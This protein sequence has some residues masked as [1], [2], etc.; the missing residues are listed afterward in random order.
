MRL[1]AQPLSFRV[2]TSNNTPSVRRKV[3]NGTSL[4]ISNEGKCA[5]HLANLVLRSAWVN[6]HN[7][8][9]N[10]NLEEL[11]NQ[12]E[13]TRGLVFNTRIKACFHPPEWSSR[14][15]KVLK[16]YEKL[17]ISILI[18]KDSSG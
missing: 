18:S 7:L 15:Q 3:T 4:I 9:Q 17:A 1:Q 8:R 14:E 11:I 12:L 16:V 2:R 6:R 13:L 10:Y 5:Y